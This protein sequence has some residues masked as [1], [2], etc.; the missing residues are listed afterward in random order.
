MKK[1]AKDKIIHYENTILAPNPKKKI[2]V[3]SLVTQLNS[4]S[5]SDTIST[6]NLNDCSSNSFEVVP[7][8]EKIEVVNSSIFNSAYGISIILLK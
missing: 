8:C 4:S 5:P 6:T 1:Q 2:K 7:H 3:Y